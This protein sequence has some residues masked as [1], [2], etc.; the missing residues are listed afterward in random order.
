LHFLSPGFGFY[1]HVIFS[2]KHEDTFK[3]D[4][5]LSALEWQ[6]E[7]LTGKHNGDILFSRGEIKNNHG[8]FTDMS[9]WT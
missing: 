9:R 8:N 1:T 7:K 6:A 3:V 4:P 5:K 2:I